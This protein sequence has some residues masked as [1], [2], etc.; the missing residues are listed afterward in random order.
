MKLFLCTFECINVCFVLL[1][2]NY[3]TIFKMN[4]TIPKE[5]LIYYYDPIPYGSFTYSVLLCPQNLTVHVVNMWVIKRTIFTYHHFGDSDS[6]SL[7]IT[8]K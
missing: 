8:K 5:N 4:H 7:S 1:T 2:T 6:S 3:V